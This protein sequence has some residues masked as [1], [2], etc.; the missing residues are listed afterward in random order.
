VDAH[1]PSEWRVA[2]EPRATPDRDLAGVNVVSAHRA[3]R[4]R[5]GLE[6]SGIGRDAA[7]IIAAGADIEHDAAAIMAE[8]EIGHDAAAI[9]AEVEEALDPAL[10]SLAGLTPLQQSILDFERQWWRQ[11]GAKEQAIRDTFEMSPTRYYQ[12]LNGLLDHPAA[13][14]YDPVLVNRLQRMRASSPRARR[15]R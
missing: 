4:E 9:M 15:I 11:P 2:P 12:S 6:S 13:L 1:A 7:A 5:T 8:V 3:A 10:G 14:R